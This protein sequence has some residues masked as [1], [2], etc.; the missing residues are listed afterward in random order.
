MV[1][2]RKAKVVTVLD[3]N[4]RVSIVLRNY[5]ISSILQLVPVNVLLPQSCAE[6][7]SSYYDIIITLSDKCLKH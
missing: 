6:L 7:M 4:I 2:Q 1:L 5:M 3:L